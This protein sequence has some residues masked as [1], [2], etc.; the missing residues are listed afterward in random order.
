MQKTRA[1]NR[2]RLFVRCFSKNNAGATAIEYALVAML[3]AM[4][5]VAALPTIAPPLN[6]TFSTVSA[7]L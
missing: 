3:I 4:A 7:K 1:A 5:I 2:L 6:S